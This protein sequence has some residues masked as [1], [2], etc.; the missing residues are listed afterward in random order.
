MEKY[1]RAG[2]ATDDNIIRRMR[3]ACWITKATDM[4]SEYVILIPLPRR[5]WLRERTSVLRYTYLACLVYAA[6]SN[7][8]LMKF[9]PRVFRRTLVT[10]ACPSRAVMYSS[11]SERGLSVD[12]AAAD[13][14]R[15]YQLSVARD[16][17]RTCKITCTDCELRTVVTKTGDT[18]TA[19]WRIKSVHLTF[20]G[21]SPRWN[22]GC[23][24]L[25][26]TSYLLILM[27]PSYRGGIVFVSDFGWWFCC[28]LRVRLVS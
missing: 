22:V 15:V 28:V 3:F 25:A 23:A 4:H 8:Q 17:P 2:Q 18:R 19:Q 16:L 7:Q 10:S 13:D 27:V 1:G 14:C 5:Q 20:C 6:V 21:F 11:G 12:T 9:V 26:E 24:S